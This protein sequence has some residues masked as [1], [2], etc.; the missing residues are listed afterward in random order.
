MI[1]KIRTAYHYLLLCPFLLLSLLI[2]SSCSSQQASPT[3]EATPS[4]Y[5]YK[6]PVE[7]K[8]ELTWPVRAKDHLAPGYLLQ[9]TCLQDENLNGEFRIDFD[10]MLELPYEVKVKAAGQSLSHFRNKLRQSYSPFFKTNPEIQL[11]IKEKK[12]LVKVLGLVEKADQYLVNKTDSLDLLIANAEG[13]QKS[14]DKTPVALYVKITRLGKNGTLKLSDYYGGSQHLVPEWQGGDVI[15]F[16]SESQ[17]ASTQQRAA[18][19][20]SDR[21]VQIIG[22]VR[23]PGEYL[24]KEDGDFFYYLARAGGPADKADLD[25]L[26]LI[27]SN[28]EK[29][30]KIAFSME[31][32]GKMPAIGAGDIVIIHANSQTAEEKREE[33]KFNLVSLVTGVATVLVLALSL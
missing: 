15:F 18:N 12:V 6:E 23:S 7:S 5:M 1:L 16:Q 8:T 3:P 33:R 4:S 9:I 30:E 24:F 27:R 32:V 2:L 21:Y 31:N 19:R 11:K 28:A 26:S 29:R 20:G 17:A 13:L 14:S 22:E 25:R 10:G